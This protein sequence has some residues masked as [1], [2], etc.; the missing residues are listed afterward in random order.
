MESCHECDN[1]SEDESVDPKTQHL[2]EI[3]PQIVTYILDAKVKEGDIL[4][5]NAQNPNT[6]FTSKT[7]PRVGIK[8]Y[9]LHLIKC[10]KTP[11]AA[12]ILWMI[13]VERFIQSLSNAIKGSGRTYPYLLTSK[14]VH[15]IVLIAFLI[16][17]KYSMDVKYP[18]SIVSKI[19]G[20]SEDELRILE[21]EFLTFVRYELYVSQDIY[22]KYLLSIEQ[23]GTILQ[24]QQPTVLDPKQ[25]SQRNAKNKSDAVQ[26]E[27][28][29][30]EA[31][32]TETNR[33]L[34]NTSEE[35]EQGRN[36][37]V[38]DS[39]NENNGWTSKEEQNFSRWHKNYESQ[40][41]NIGSPHQN[42]TNT[43]LSSPKSYFDTRNSN[44][45]RDWSESDLCEGGDNDTLMT[46]VDYDDLAEDDLPGDVILI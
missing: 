34:Q 17:H 22:Q 28:N 45:I 8:E 2:L 23:F 5:T 40:I 13:Y 18:F 19:S 7:I 35:H 41:Q 42:I 43:W 36:F 16:A 29:N 9:M 46:I 37:E 25:C 1:D 21:S 27:R 31:T 4:S 30:S 26:N 44:H 3:L 15:K 10:F 38:G 39:Y 11:P 6:Y 14:N 12:L 33:I 32:Q 20:V 24:L